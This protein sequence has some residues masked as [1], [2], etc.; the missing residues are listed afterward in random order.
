MFNK[1][2]IIW[3]LLTLKIIIGVL[4]IIYTVSGGTKAVSVTQKQQMAIIFIGMFAAFFIIL[5]CE[6]RLFFM[7]ELSFELSEFNLQFFVLL[8]SSLS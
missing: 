6:G 8:Q 4:V 1:L 2:D 5:F 3:D 7:L